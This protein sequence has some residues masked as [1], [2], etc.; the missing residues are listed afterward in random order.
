MITKLEQYQD[1]LAQVHDFDFDCF[2]V[3]KQVGRE[4]SFSMLVY[5]MMNDLPLVSTLPQGVTINNDKLISFL[6]EIQDGYRV[7]VA[8]HNDLHGADVA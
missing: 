7:D 6:R 1:V 4:H 3:C 2:S 8:Y 5:K